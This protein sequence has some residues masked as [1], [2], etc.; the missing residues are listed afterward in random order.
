MA[1]AV[2]GGPLIAAGP[3]QAA[4]PGLSSTDAAASVD[5]V[6]V[7]DGVRLRSS[8]GGSRVI[9]LLYYGDYGQIL[10]AN[11]S[12]SWCKFRLGGRSTSGLPVGTTG[13]ASC[14]YFATEDGRRL[15]EVSADSL[16]TESPESE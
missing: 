10:N 14:S 3:A 11:L 1:S 7:A 2:F 15:A 16:E 9:G 12:S 4:M 13:W 6:V 8:A 5:A